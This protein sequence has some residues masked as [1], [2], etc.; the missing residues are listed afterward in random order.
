MIQ[1][2]GVV[3]LLNESGPHIGP[4]G[5]SYVEV[6]LDELYEEGIVGRIPPHGPEG[7]KGYLIRSSAERALGVGATVMLMPLARGN[8]VRLRR[9][10]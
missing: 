9:L 1:P 2:S 5:V 6:I 7:L 10:N 3:A 4:G 8:R